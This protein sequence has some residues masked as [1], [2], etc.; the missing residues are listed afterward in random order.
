MP[1]SGIHEIVGRKISSKYNY[2]DNY[3][4]YLGLIAP[5]SVNYLGFAPKE[6]RWNAHLRDKDL[7]IWK[8]NI[9]NFYNDN[10]DNYNESF[11]KGYITHIMTDIVYDESFYLDVTLPMKSINKVDHEAHLYML[12]E[13]KAYSS[14]NDFIYTKEILSKSNNT[15]NIRNISKELLSNWKNKIINEEKVDIK[16]Q[17]ITNKIIEDLTTKVEEELIK[18]KVL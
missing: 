5:D 6:D 7:S 1:T 2:L 4:F 12:E 3:D 10:K 13:M 17:F 11:I 9:I 14:N 18:Y 8:S 15:Y 16:P